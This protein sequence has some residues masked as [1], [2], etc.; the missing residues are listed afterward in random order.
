MPDSADQVLADR[1]DVADQL[2]VSEARYRELFDRVPVGLYRTRPDGRIVE[3]N[4]AL[5]AMLG[6]DRTELLAMNAAELFV[7][8]GERWEESARLER[9]GVVRG[10]PLRLR[11]KDGSSIWVEDTARVVRGPTGE[12]LAYEGSIVDVSERRR[13][14]E[15]LRFL[16]DTGVRLAAAL[17]YD[18]TLRTLAD[19][20]VP[21]LAD[22]STVCDIGPD[23]VTRRAAVAFAN[24]ALDEV[25]EAL[26]AYRPTA[27]APAST[28]ARAI[29]TGRP[30]LTPQVPPDYFEQIAQD[31]QHLALLR[32]LGFT[33]SIA[34]PLGARGRTLGAIAL[35]RGPGRPPFEQEDLEVA[36]ELARRAALGVD[37]ARLYREAQEQ[38]EIHVRLNQELRALAE[39]RDR[40]TG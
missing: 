28:I 33:S 21:F 37:N 7:D 39:S 19:A 4:P 35:F 27:A 14:V 5:A 15:W 20:C 10:F 29:R 16:T 22:W 3:A 24:P 32:R 25:A 26:R 23:G 18:A 1:R 40:P 8:R 9:E 30:Q 6:Y 31:E 12:V 38:A 11:R 34:V 2:R 36:E 13:A 17:E